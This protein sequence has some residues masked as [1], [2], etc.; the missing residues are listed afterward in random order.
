MT[1]Y[2]Q[3]NDDD[4]RPYRAFYSQMTGRVVAIV[5]RSKVGYELLWADRTSV[6]AQNMDELVLVARAWTVRLH[7]SA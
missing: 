2:A 3:A 6:R 1:N 5:S 7:A 4:S